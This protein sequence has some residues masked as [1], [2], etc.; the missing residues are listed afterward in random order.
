VTTPH[1]VEAIKLTSHS[2]G[3]TQELGASLG[4]LL[5]SGDVVCLEGSLGAGKTCLTQGIG[6]GLGLNAPIT[7]PTF[8]IVHEYALPALPYRLYHIDLYRVQ[9]TAEACATGLEDHFFGDGICVI[10]WADRVV[11]ILPEDRLWITLRYLSD[12]QRELAFQAWGQRYVELLQQLR[13]GLPDASRL[14]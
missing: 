7:S 14:R 6:R 8:I 2:A 10:E 1:T 5:H 12:S 3:Q 13:D 11:D 9:S 4:R